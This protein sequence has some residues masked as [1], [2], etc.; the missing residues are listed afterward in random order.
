LED[1]PNPGF[2]VVTKPFHI[3]VARGHHPT[4]I[5]L[6]L[7][8][9]FAHLALAKRRQ[10]LGPLIETMRARRTVWRVG[11]QFFDLGFAPQLR[12]LR[13]TRVEPRHRWNINSCIGRPFLLSPRPDNR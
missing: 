10:L 11:T 12:H 9:P 1:L 7:H 6:P 8:K 4:S 5:F 3:L 2:D 13:G